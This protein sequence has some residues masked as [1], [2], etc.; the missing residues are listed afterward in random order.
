MLGLINIHCVRK[1]VNP[2]T[3]LNRNVK[4]QGSLT[5][6]CA[7]YSEYIYKRTEKIRCKIVFNS[8]VIILQISMTKYLSFQHNFI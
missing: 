4:T 6:L 5:N 1:N 8:G 7:L 3:I 2:W